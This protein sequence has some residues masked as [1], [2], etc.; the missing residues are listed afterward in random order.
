MLTLWVGCWQVSVSA[1]YRTAL[2]SDSM[3]NQPGSQA[4]CPPNWTEVKTVSSP[5]CLKG[6]TGSCE[7]IWGLHPPNTGITL[8]INCHLGFG[9]TQDGSNVLDHFEEEMT[10]YQARTVGPM[11][12]SNLV[13]TKVLQTI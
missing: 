7:M 6:L 13:T 11:A 5:R 12:A 9:N 8:W 4:P 10:G 2:V 3:L 1:I